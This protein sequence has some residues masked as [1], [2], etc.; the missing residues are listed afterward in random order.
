MLLIH[1]SHSQPLGIWNSTSHLSF[2]EAVTTTELMRLTTGGNLGI[3][4]AVPVNKLDVGGSVAIGASYSGTNTALANGLIVEGKVGIGTSSPDA[5]YVM[6]ITNSTIATQHALLM[7]MG[8]HTAFSA[9]IYISHLDGTGV[10]GNKYG[11][12]S[13]ANDN[14]STYKVGLQGRGIGNSG[15]KRGVRGYATGTGS[16]NYGIYGECDALATINY[17]GFFNGSV[18]TTGSY[19]PSDRKLKKNVEDYSGALADVMSLQVKSYEYLK[20]GKYAKMQLPKGR[21]LGLLAE[22]LEKTFPFLIKETIFDFSESDD[23]LL[24]RKLK[25]EMDFKAVN[26]TGLI[27]VL[28]KAIQEQ[29]KLIEE[30]QHEVE[31]L[32]TNK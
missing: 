5:L 18:F 20:E 30:L 21:Q 1:N 6:E 31:D 9:A 14:N 11:V 16:A 13:D 15:N 27:P 24:P 12:Y 25:D 4:V 19:L 28:L 26:Y 29:Q 8:P 10:T 22:D 3:G 7:K 32:K 2:G 17:A 23:V